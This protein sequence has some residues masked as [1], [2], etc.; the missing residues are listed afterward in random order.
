MTKNS[1][2]P[3]PQ[4]KPRRWTPSS[5][6]KNSTTIEVDYAKTADLALNFKGSKKELV[7]WV[8]K[9]RGQECDKCKCSNKVMENEKP[10]KREQAS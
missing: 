3:F 4:F 8:K 6:P 7:E 1:S 9:N 10:N 2:S 5:Q